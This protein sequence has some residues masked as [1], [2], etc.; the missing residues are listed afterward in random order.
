LNHVNEETFNIASMNRTGNRKSFVQAYNDYALQ[1]EKGFSVSRYPGSYA[2]VAY[3]WTS[4]SLGFWKLESNG[5]SLL[6]FFSPNTIRK[7]GRAF[8]A[9]TTR[10]TYKQKT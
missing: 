9:G 8:D 4:P 3:S 1:R 7:G 5:F 10:Y 2:F 6:S